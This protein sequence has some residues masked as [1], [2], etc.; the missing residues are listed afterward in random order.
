MGEERD[1]IEGAAH[2]SA[3]NRKIPEM[4]VLSVIYSHKPVIWEMVRTPQG[5]FL[6]GSRVESNRPGRDYWLLD[7]DGKELIR[8]NTSAWILNLAPDFILIGEVA[9]DGTASIKALKRQGKEED[10]LLKLSGK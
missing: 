6:I 1:G 5:R 2:F 3:E 9:E 4:T 10:N 7:S 8:I